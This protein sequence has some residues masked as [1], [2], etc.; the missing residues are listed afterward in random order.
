MQDGDFVSVDYV[1]RVKGTND[2]FDLTIEEVAKKENV[3]NPKVKYKPVTLIVG[4]GFIL[5]GLDDA[6]RDMKVGERKTFEVTPERAFGER[7][8]EMVKP[9]PAARFKEQNIEPFPGAV[10]NIGELRGRIV[11]VDGGRVKVD[12]NHPLAGKTLVYDLEV[13]ASV[14][15]Q[16][17]K[18]K[19]VV[20]Y[21]TGLD[22]V[23]A[24]VSEGAAEIRI[25]KD[26]DV[27]R[28]V[29]SMI[30]DT[31]MKWCG[32]DKVRFIETFERTP[33]RQAKAG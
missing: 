2:I 19:S 29:K 3:F 11:S 1:G 27:V 21:F 4:G 6:L 7:K 31:A 10:I 9:I 18:V 33:E 17:E 30:A 28:P 25:M 8:D 23:D 5:R 22:D 13:K 24:K 12:F 32:V 15:K 26:V 14:D 16:D 20:F